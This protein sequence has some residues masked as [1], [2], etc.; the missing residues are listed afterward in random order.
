MKHVKRKQKRITIVLWLANAI[1][2]I[3]LINRLYE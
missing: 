2:L 1:L 3:Y